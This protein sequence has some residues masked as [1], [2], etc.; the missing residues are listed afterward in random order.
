MYYQV[1]LTRV[2]KRQ[3]LLLKQ[4]RRRKRRLM[5]ERNFVECVGFSLAQPNLQIL[6]LSQF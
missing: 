2:N 1:T 5:G 6:I 4:L 3:F